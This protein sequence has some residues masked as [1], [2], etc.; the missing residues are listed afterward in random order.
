MEVERKSV[1]VS[2]AGGFLHFVTSDGE[3]LASIGV[4]PGMVPA[5]PYLDLV[6]PGAGI[7]VEGLAVL[8]P[9]ARALSGRVGFGEAHFTTACNPDFVPDRPA[10]FERQMRVMI[11]QLAAKTDRL[12]ARQ[13]ALDKIERIPTAPAPASAAAPDQ[14]AEVIETVAPGAE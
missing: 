6:P 5:A 4:P 7:E 1:L 9:Q 8:E 2:A 14:A 10:Q 12:D 11:S 3:L 13:R